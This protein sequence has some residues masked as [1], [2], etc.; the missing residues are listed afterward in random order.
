MGALTAWLRQQV[1]RLLN[2]PLYQAP[3]LAIESMHLVRAYYVAAELKLADAL[4]ERPQTCAELAQRL[5]VDAGELERQLQALA[6][7]RIFRR[8]RQGVYHLTRRSRPLQSDGPESLRAWISLVASPAMW[9]AYACTLEGVRSGRNPFELAHG[10]RF[11]DHLHQDEKLR[12]AFLTAMDGWT[13]WQAQALTAAM[14]FGRY[15]QIVD[16]GGGLGALL[17][18]ILQRHPRCRGVLFD[19]PETVAAAQARFVADGVAERCEFVGGDFFESVP[20]GGDAY[21]L[22]HVLRD[23][24]DAHARQLLLTCRAGMSGDAELIVIDPLTNPATG[25]DRLVK[26]L[27]LEI[28][29][30]QMGRL[31]TRAEMEALLEGAGFRV[32]RVYWTGLVD[33]PITTAKLG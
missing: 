31:R 29:V 21:M 7:F 9:Q 8:D 3:L 19:Q 22:K 27:N 16:V 30:F 23:W 10:A 24:D 1:M 20:R 15:R 4:A 13:H 26:L 32:Q 17:R 2:P 5:A 14:D 11:F 28:G 25:R 6:A 12:Q 33:S 18:A